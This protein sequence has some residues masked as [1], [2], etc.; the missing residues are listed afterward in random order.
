MRFSAQTT[1]ARRRALMIRRGIRFVQPNEPEPEQ[2]MSYV[3][4]YFA[5]LVPFC[6]LDGVWLTVMGRLLYRPTLGDILLPSVNLAPAVVFYLAY[7]IGI[8]VFAAVPAL[9]QGSVTPALVYA[10]LFGTLAYATYDLTNYAT[11]RNWTLQISVLDVAWGAFASAAAAAV[12]FYATK[13]IP[14]A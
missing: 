7:P 1:A 3:T 6:L 12:A 13:A 8:L 10:A 5:I 14:Q 11:L 9:K 2:T 4:T